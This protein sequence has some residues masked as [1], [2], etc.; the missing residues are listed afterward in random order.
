[1]FRPKAFRE[2]EVSLC[3]SFFFPGD[4]LTAGLLAAL[5]K[6]PHMYLLNTL[7]PFSPSLKKSTVWSLPGVPTSSVDVGC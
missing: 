4:L 1:M 7:F 6:S 3:I 5:R 2:W